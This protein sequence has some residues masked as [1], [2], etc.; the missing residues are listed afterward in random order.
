MNYILA[1]LKL[2]WPEIENNLDKIYIID[3]QTN[4][5]F[6][7]ISNEIIVDDILK[8]KNNCKTKFLFYLISEGVI[9]SILEKIQ[10]I[11]DLLKDTIDPADVIYATG[12]SDGK[13]VYENCCV[14]NNWVNKISVLCSNAHYFSISLTYPLT[15]LDIQYKVKEKEKL[16]LSFNKMPRQH[17]LDLL[18]MVLENKYLDKSFYS[19]E[20]SSYW[21]SYGFT[22]VP[23]GYPNIKSNLNLLPL[24]LN[25]TPN[26]LN[27]IHVI[28]DDIKYFE[29]SYFSIVT[30]TSFYDNQP[31]GIN[32]MFI[33]EKVL[34]CFGC[35]HPFI[36]LG[37]PYSLAEL[38]K[39]G[40]KTFEPFIDESYDIIE[41]DKER[42][43]CIFNEIHRLMAKSTEEWITWQSQIQEIVKYNNNYFHSSIDYSS[44]K[45]VDKYFV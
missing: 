14:K 8:A 24:R 37:R 33:T 10:C 31:Y 23:E 5:N 4:T 13:E 16:F 20:G 34:K 41:D 15:L 28:P 25:I 2:I 6:A 38:R 40:Y 21:S 42:L 22:T 18:E 36:L 32:S 30:E 1:T 29:E 3:A 19:F 45:N 11:V 9:F 27:P 26:R 44:T 43:T 39:I 12:A 7:T 17:R 35:M